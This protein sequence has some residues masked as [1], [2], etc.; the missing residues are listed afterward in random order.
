MR[1]VG[2]LAPSGQYPCTFCVVIRLSFG[3]DGWAN[4]IVFDL[5]LEN[6]IYTF[7]GTKRVSETYLN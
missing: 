5:S 6:K 7:F 3:I 4:F 2:I 1:K